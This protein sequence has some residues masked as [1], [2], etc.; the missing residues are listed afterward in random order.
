MELVIESVQQDMCSP[1]CPFLM[2]SDIFDTSTLQECEPF[3]HFVEKHVST[4][5]NHIFFDK[6]KNY[7]LRMCNDLLRRLSRS[8]NT[9]FCGRI[10][11]FLAHLFPLEEKSGLNLVSQFNVDNRTTYNTKS[12]VFPTR[13]KSEGE[14]GSEDGDSGEVKDDVKPATVDQIVDYALYRKFWSLQDFFNKPVKLFDKSA[15][16]MFSSNLSAVIKVFESYKLDDV[17]FQ[18]APLTGTEDVYFAKYLTNEKLLDLQLND[19]TFRRNILLQLLIVFQYL[20]A[21]VK[22]KTP[23]LILTEEQNS[24]V[25]E[26]TEKVYNLLKVNIVQS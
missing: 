12:E 8:Q 18:K 22:F 25:K 19:T 5:K 13:K 9:I 6:G 20:N 26:L 7:L 4:W 3:F 1:L 14:V 21:P 17:K 11:L 24:S 10:Q 15:W 2:M 16:K 23:A